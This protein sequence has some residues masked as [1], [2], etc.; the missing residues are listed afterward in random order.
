MNDDDDDDDDDDDNL[1]S[2]IKNES[3]SSP[4]SIPVVDNII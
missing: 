1:F 4:S 3:V 2:S